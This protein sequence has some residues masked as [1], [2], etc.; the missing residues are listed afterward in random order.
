MFVER[1]IQ[2]IRPGKW[3][4]LEVIDKK[5]N[6]IEGRLGFPPKR[7]LR[8][9]VG[10]HNI[11]TLIIEREWDSLTLMEAAYLKTFADPEWQALGAEFDAIA[12]ST[13]YELYFV[14]S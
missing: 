10:G 13:Q 5:F 4:D 8:C 7:R 3:A 2:Q 11:N 9:Y 12:E 14:L 6:A 1:Q